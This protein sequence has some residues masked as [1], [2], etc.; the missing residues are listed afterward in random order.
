ME[1]YGSRTPSMDHANLLGRTCVGRNP[2]RNAEASGT[3]RAVY[4][5]VFLVEDGDGVLVNV[6]CLGARLTS[7][8]VAP[9]T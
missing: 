1:L 5:S 2:D 9:A 8:P 7:P 4:D 3:I 6:V